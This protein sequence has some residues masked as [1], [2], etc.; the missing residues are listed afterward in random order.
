VFCLD[1]K[2]IFYV[3]SPGLIRTPILNYGSQTVNDFENI[4]KAEYPLRRIGETEDVANAIVFV[5]SEK[6]SFITG[7]VI[8]VDGGSAN[9]APFQI[10]KNT[11]SYCN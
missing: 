1:L 11:S 6:A 8:P 9:C 5:S 7:S 3:Q 4:C 10:I 2:N